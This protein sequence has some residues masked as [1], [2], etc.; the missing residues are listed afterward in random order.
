[1]D[2][3]ASDVR[4]TKIKCS[5]SVMEICHETPWQPFKS[6][7][8]FYSSLTLLYF[9]SQVI[10]QTHWAVSYTYGLFYQLILFYTCYFF[11]D[12]FS[13]LPEFIFPTNIKYVTMPFTL[14]KD[15]VEI[16]GG[17]KGISWLIMCAGVA[18]VENNIVKGRLSFLQIFLKLLP[19]EKTLKYYHINDIGCKC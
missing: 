13:F 8:V 1:M 9:V 7:F 18:R 11:F 3:I 17:F 5:S 4:L 10:T 6:R 19:L 16:Q 15:I 12:Y 14:P 2:Y